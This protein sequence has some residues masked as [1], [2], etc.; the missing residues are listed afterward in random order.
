M[1]PFSQHNE[2]LITR[3]QCS[4]CVRESAKE[5]N[6]KSQFRRRL[7]VSSKFLSYKKRA[8]CDFYTYTLIFK[9]C[10]TC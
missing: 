4:Q 1:Q 7:K 8:G 5:I 2:K 9:P 10:T 6:E 3:V